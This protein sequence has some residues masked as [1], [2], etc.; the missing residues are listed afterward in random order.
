MTSLLPSALQ[1]YESSFL[2]IPQQEV[3][4]ADFPEGYMMKKST[5][6]YFIIAKSIFLEK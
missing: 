6:F 1:P 5:F 4:C 2:K 3:A